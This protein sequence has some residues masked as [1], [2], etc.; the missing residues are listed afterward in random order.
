MWTNTAVNPHLWTRMHAGS[1]ACM[2][3]PIQVSYVDLPAITPDIS[4]SQWY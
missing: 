1:H 3:M 2:H 4:L